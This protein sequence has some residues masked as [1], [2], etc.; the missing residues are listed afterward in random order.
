MK[1]PKSLLLVLSLSLACLQFASPIDASEIALQEPGIPHLNTQ[2]KNKSEDVIKS[3]GINTEKTSDNR[4]DI[5]NLSIFANR[6]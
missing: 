3:L 1:R 4:T 5:M 6:S 2:E